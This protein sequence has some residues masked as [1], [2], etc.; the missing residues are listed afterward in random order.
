MNV[1]FIERTRCPC[2]LESRFRV[3]RELP[4]ADPVMRRY[5]DDFYRDVGG[6]DHDALAGAVYSV[7]HCEACGA[8]FQRDIPD[9]H[10]LGK[11]YEEWIDPVKVRQVYECGHPLH[12][13]VCLSR[14]METILRHFN[15]GPAALKVLDLGMGWGNW[16]LFA[17]AYGCETYGLEV[18][19]SRVN[20]ARRLGLNVLNYNELAAHRFHVVR[21]EQVFEHLP[22]PLDTLRR[23]AG[24]LEPGGMIWI[25]VP[26]ASD[27]AG[28]VRQW[29]WT[30]PKDSPRSLN[31]LAPLE[32]L[33]G[34]THAALIA[35][36][37][38]VGLIPA[39]VP[40]HRAS[41]KP[42]GWKRWWRRH[43]PRG[44]VS[45]IPQGTELYFTPGPEDRSGRT[46]V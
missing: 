1:H 16:C 5:L 24:L 9:D 4:Y 7:A 14:Q 34:F 32:H 6:V 18:S 33:N 2:C 23:L 41:D 42:A 8:F 36:A 43:Q 26:D 3:L 17:R 46:G 13:Y 38:K 20:H 11:L 37:G 19:A 35:I 40:R 25:S 22:D 12:H 29:D 31:A 27:L 39:V 21:A 30:A 44:P 15:R 10:L 28:R 45:R